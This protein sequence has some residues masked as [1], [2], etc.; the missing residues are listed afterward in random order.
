MTPLRDTQSRNVTCTASY[1]IRRWHCY[2]PDVFDN[3]AN[4]IVNTALNDW[5][6]MEDKMRKT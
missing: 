2:L 4:Y 1:V 6:I 3:T 5:V